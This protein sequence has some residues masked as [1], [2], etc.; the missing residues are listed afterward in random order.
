MAALRELWKRFILKHSDLSVNVVLKGGCFFFKTSQPLCTGE[1]SLVSIRCFEN[2][3]P[4]HIEPVKYIYIL[5][6]AVI[7]RY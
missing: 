7:K 2:T 6:F 3:H 5:T 1:Y 4:L